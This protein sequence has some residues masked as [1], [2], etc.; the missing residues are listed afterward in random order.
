[1]SCFEFQKNFFGS[2]RMMDWE[3]G[4]VRDRVDS[5]CDSLDQ[6]WWEFYL[7]SIDGDVR[8]YQRYQEEMD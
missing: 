3:I 5:Q 8:G 1:M 7:G 6:V 2:V 4:E